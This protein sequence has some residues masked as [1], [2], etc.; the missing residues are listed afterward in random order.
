[1][2]IISKY[3]DNVNTC[4]SKMKI[5]QTYISIKSGIDV[6]KLS[7]LL[8]GTQEITITDMEKIAGALGK[9]VEYFLAEDFSLSDAMEFGDVDAVFY[10]GEPTKQQEELAKQLIELVKNADEVLSARGRYLMA[11][12]E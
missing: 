2:I 5:K 1:M 7:R 12:G 4:L 3:I 10:A 6:K 11:T 9:S 8:T